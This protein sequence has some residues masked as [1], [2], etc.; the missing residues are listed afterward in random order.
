[1]MTLTKTPKIVVQPKAMFNK[2]ATIIL[3]TVEQLAKQEFPYLG[4]H[5]L[6]VAIKDVALNKQFKAEEN[7]ALPIYLGKKMILLV[8]L[9]K[10]SDFSLTAL[11]MAIRKVLFVSYLQRENVIEVIPHSDDIENVK[12]VVEGICL[13][14]Y[15]WNKYR[16]AGKDKDDW[17]GKTIYLVSGRQKVVEN[18]I[19]ICLGVNLTRDLVNDNADLITADYLENVVRR[20][21]HGRK[22]IKCEILNGKKL[23]ERGLDLHLAVNQGSPKAPKLIIVKYQGA[24][25]NS[26]YT[27]IVGKGITFDTGGLNLKSSGHIETMRSDMAGAAAVIGV[28]RNVLSLGIK[29]NVIFAIGIAENAIGSR[30][31]KPGDVFRSFDGKTVEIAN[32]DAE[33]R[34]VLADAIAYI[35]K[36]YRPT[37]LIDIATLTG[38]CVVALGHDY[39]GLIATDESLSRELLDLA[40][41]TDDRAWRLP[42]YPELK[43]SVKSQI[44]D[45]RNLGYPKGAAGTLTAAEFLRQFTDNLPWAHLDIAGTAFAENSGRL[46]FGYGA[47]GAGVRL[48]TA[49]FQNH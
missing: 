7:E 43:E 19:E 22:D 18:T 40:Q 38:A 47:T 31:Y 16:S 11:R 37:R 35:S 25:K 46:Y 28:L 36:N 44:A 33:G 30:A 14:T 32:T 34:L 24:K 3:F 12:A 20:L 10:K 5:A 45:I 21:I 6:R 1:M 4:Q 2:P 48:L 26:D 29:K 42:S 23:K 17:G 27:A 41:K 9:G 39:S 8:G 15:T 49:Y 13:G